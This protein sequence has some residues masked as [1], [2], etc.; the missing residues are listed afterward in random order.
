MSLVTLCRTSIP[1]AES[2]LPSATSPG[3]HPCHPPRNFVTRCSAGSLLTSP[4]GHSFSDS[5]FATHSLKRGC[6]PSFCFYPSSLQTLSLISS[7]S[8]PSTRLLPESCLYQ[9][10]ST[11]KLNS[12]SIHFKR[13]LFCHSFPSDLLFSCF[14]FKVIVYS[15]QG[16]LSGVRVDKTSK[17]S[18]T[19]PKTKPRSGHCTPA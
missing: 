18:L 10:L 12:F 6:F 14:H 11:S 5:S 19:I 2:F 9:Y 7:T 15:R 16:I 8:W 1:I 4:S 13:S 17:S 3:F